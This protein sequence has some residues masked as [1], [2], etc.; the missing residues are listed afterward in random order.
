M[1]AFPAAQLQGHHGSRKR[2]PVDYELLLGSAILL[3]KTSGALGKQD[4]SGKQDDE[5]T[6]V[7]C[8]TTVD[9]QGSVHARQSWQTEVLKSFQPTSK[10]QL[11]DKS[12]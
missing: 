10:T 4:M 7:D 5:E 6:A 12:A 3:F 9:G 8:L 2:T 1:F 11:W